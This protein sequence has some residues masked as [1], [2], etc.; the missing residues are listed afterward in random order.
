MIIRNRRG[1][2]L[3]RADLVLLLCLNTGQSTEPSKRF[4]LSQ[5]LQR[6]NDDAQD[7]VEAC[8]MMCACNSEFHEYQ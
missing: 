1:G 7:E 5:A 2:V 8:Q 6:G 4:A 3:L